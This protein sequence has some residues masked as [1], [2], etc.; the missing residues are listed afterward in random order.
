MQTLSAIPFSIKQGGSA[1]EVVIKGGLVSRGKDVF[2]LE[3]LGAIDV[4]H[5][6]GGFANMPLHE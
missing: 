1:R 6:S 2:A 4:L 5:I 3:Q